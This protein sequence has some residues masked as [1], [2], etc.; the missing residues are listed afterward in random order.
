AW[1]RVLRDFVV[2]KPAMDLN[3]RVALIT[4]GKRIGLVVAE[5]LAK[6][7]V[8]VALAYARSREE[9][10]SA[11]ALVRAHGRRSAILQADLS[12]PDACRD[13][14]AAAVQALGRLD[15]LINMASVYKER[16]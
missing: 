2:N 1:L 6:R 7:G 16:P 14:V 15:V 12:Q 9:A 3:G 11:A 8:D 4:G 13:L 5:E 10:E